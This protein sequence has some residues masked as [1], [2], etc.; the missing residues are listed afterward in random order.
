MS[1]Y[2]KCSDSSFRSFCLIRFYTHRPDWSSS[3]DIEWND[4]AVPGRS[5]RFLVFCAFPV[6][7]FPAL[8]L[9]LCCNY[10]RSAVLHV[11]FSGGSEVR[12]GPSPFS[13][14]RI[15]V[16]RPRRHRHPGLPPRCRTCYST[17][18]NPTNNSI[19]PQTGRSIFNKKE[20]TLSYFALSS[21]LHAL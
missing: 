10:Q 3:P 17:M 4:D 2:L 9:E 15:R 1:L 5:A 12:V 18:I 7:P 13:L 21:V 16:T 14:L 20:N 19:L 11:L 8:F 6:I